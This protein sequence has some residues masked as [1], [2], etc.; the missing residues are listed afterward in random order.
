VT[1]DPDH[2]PDLFWALQG[3]GGNFGVVTEV[4]TRLHPLAMVT[5]GMIAFGMDQARSVLEGWPDLVASAD[6]ALDVMFGV[7][8]T[9]A[10]R[11]LFT[12]PT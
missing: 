8:S 10:G 7:M 3:G 1:A 2:E 6:D 12:A 4:R 9:P 11:V 5:T